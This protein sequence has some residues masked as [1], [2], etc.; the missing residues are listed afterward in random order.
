LYTYNVTFGSGA[1]RGFNEEYRELKHKDGI[2]T[3][4]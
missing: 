2:I 3:I 1:R 4:L